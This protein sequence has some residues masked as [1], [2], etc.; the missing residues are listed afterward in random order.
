[1]SLKKHEQFINGQWVQPSSGHY[2]TIKNPANGVALAA[3]AKG[4]TADVDKAVAAARKAFGP[5][6]AKTASAR[7]DYLY[8]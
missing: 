6:S 1:M 3:A 5:W 2:V 8:A 4:N 7:A